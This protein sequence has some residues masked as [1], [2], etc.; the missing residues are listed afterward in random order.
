V[1][2]EEGFQNALKKHV[3]KIS[4]G[5]FVTV[6][7]NRVKLEKHGKLKSGWSRKKRS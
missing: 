2:G 6:K 5:G 7:S 4:P 3:G 1:G